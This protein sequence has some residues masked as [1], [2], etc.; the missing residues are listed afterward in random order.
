VLRR[1]RGLFFLVHDESIG[2]WYG[3]QT[4]FE[5]LATNW[6]GRTTLPPSMNSPRPHL[7]C[8]SGNKSW[9]TSFSSHHGGMW[10]N[11]VNLPYLTNR[12]YLVFTKSSTLGEL[13]SKHP[14]HECQYEVSRS[15][16]ITNCQSTKGTLFPIFS[17]FS[18]GP[19]LSR[20]CRPEIY[21]VKRMIYD[22]LVQRTT[23]LN[24]LVNDTP[25]STFGSVNPLCKEVDR[26][27]SLLD[28]VLEQ[29]YSTNHRRLRQVTNSFAPRRSWAYVRLLW[30]GHFFVFLPV[31]LVFPDRRLWGAD[32]PLPYLRRRGQNLQVWEYGTRAKWQLQGTS[33]EFVIPLC[34]NFARLMKPN[35][36][37][38]NPRSFLNSG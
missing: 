17:R 13:R 38:T 14:G 18:V 23:T 4:I 20:V 10:P 32:L 27:T 30:C 21:R 36:V 29:E 12:C 25:E 3:S 16:C 37:R 31:R 1:G 8:I 26:L 6:T 24:A 7:T 34:S 19:K 2:L 9:G 5:S 35:F 11:Y 33:Q 15:R 22:T 28:D